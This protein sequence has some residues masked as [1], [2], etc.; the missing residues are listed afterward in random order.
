MGFGNYILFLCA[1]SW[2]I[3]QLSKGILQLILEHQFSLK[4]CLASGGMPSS[5]SAFV[6]CCSV[7]MGYIYGFGSG[8]F[9]LSAV[10]AIVVMYDACNV[11]RQSG[12]QAKAI[13][14]ILENWNRLTPEL[15][16]LQ[17][18]V[19]LGH[20]PLQVIVGALL[21]LTVAVIAQLV[22]SAL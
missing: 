3:A 18:K 8:I 6:T 11:R 20:T 10:V 14:L 21:G 15:L 7:T 16:D 13:N 12:E 9:A 17:V 5:H 2:F 22:G 1:L 4:R 19:L